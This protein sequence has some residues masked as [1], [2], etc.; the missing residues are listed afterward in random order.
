MAKMQYK[1]NYKGQSDEYKEK[2]SRDEFRGQKTRRARIRAN[3]EVKQNND[4]VI[5]K[6]QRQ[7]NRKNNPV[8]Q[9]GAPDRE[10]AQF[11]AAGEDGKRSL[12]NMS[13]DNN[14]FAVDNLEDF[15][16]AAYGSG[17]SKGQ[18]KFNVNDARGLMQKG[19]F[20]AEDLNK[21]AQGL[22]EGQVSGKAQAFLDR[23]MAE[24]KDKPE[25]DAEIDAG[26]ENPTSDPDTTTTD[27]KEDADKLKDDYVKEITQNQ[28]FDREFGDNQNTI[29]D[30]NKIYGN[31][32]Q[33]NQDFSVNIGS[34]S[35]GSGSGASGTTNLNNMQSAAA[36]NAL[37]ENQ[38]ERSQ[39][40][41]NPYAKAQGNIDATKESVG[42]DESTKAGNE[43]YGSLRDLYR[44]QTTDYMTN[45][46]GDYFN[47]ENYK[48]PKWNAPATPS[49]ISPEYEDPNA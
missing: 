6:E 26:T 29:G 49:K 27:P 20:S 10:G 17:S 21:Y 37:N 14:P 44:A 46:F 34:Q 41:F 30:D 39:A 32:N 11:Y 1:K 42:V 38:Y 15:D 8:A 43:L 22:D 35:S 4:G 3:K 13:D 2:Y 19:N 47:Q 28:S 40:K 45:L 48:P 9:M 16:L 25:T 5:T 33:G 12:Q 36:Y 24:V 31:V 23:K 7:E 18:D